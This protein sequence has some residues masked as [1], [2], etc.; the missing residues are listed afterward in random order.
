MALLVTLAALW[1]G[2]F[3]FMRVAVPAM[4]PIPLAFVR[5]ALAASALLAL[6]YAQIVLIV[7][8]VLA[9]LLIRVLVGT[10]QTLRRVG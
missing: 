1:G 2:S 6:A 3:V 10:R 4:G 9:V 7:L 5:V 8:M